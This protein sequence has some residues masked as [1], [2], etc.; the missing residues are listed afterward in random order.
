MQYCML[1]MVR[2]SQDCGRLCGFS[3]ILLGRRCLCIHGLLATAAAATAAAHCLGNL[4]EK[5]RA[6]LTVLVEAQP[7]R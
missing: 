1:P 2:W 5:S 3:S 6:M 7:S 4:H